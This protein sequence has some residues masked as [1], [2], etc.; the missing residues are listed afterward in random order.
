M[1]YIEIDENMIILAQKIEILKA[2]G[3]MQF[4]WYAVHMSVMCSG[5]VE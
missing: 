1:C 4:C 5:E 3:R 2:I